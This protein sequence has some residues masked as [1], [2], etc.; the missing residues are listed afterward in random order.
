MQS[1]PCLICGSND[2]FTVLYEANFT[3]ADFSQRVFSA[4]RLP[5]RIHYRIVRCNKDGMVRSNP[6]MP[7]EKAAQLYKHSQLN[8]SDEIENL[9]PTYVAAL[10]PVLDSI[11]KGAGILEIGCGNGFILEALE[12]QGY[13]GIKGIE[14]S[15][16]AVNKAS[17]RIKPHLICDI[18]RPGLLKEQSLDFIYLFQTLDHLHDPKSFIQECHRLLKPGGYILSFQH[19]VESLSARILGE[20]SP[21]IDI[22][23]I[24]LFSP[25][26][27]RAFFTNNGF[28]VQKVS[29]PANI[30][31]LR[32]LVWLLPLPKGIKDFLLTLP[33]FFLKQRLKIKLGNLCIVARKI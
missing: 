31:S 18:F 1:T 15:Q 28:C 20:R 21:I 23:H 33:K 3:E 30:L 12:A 26:S 16:D 13:E 9:V 32:H 2:N 6:V 24:Y 5:D 27:I 29:K 10:Q 25:S 8:Y 11:G 17:P 19:N 7:H 4:R 22:E 14:P